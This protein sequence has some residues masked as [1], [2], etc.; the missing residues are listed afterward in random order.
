MRGMVSNSVAP[1]LVMMTMSLSGAREG[2]DADDAG[3]LLEQR[4]AAV[5]RVGDVAAVARARR[6]CRCWHP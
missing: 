2:R 3:N 4:V 5:E 1:S 6:R